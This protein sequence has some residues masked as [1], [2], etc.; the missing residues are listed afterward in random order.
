MGEIPMHKWH[1][2]WNFEAM[3]ARNR[4]AEEQGWPFRESDEVGAEVKKKRGGLFR[5]LRRKG[6]K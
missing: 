2:P 1:D 4:E 3:A 5:M 6:L